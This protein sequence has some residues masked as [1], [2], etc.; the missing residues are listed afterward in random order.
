MVY[1]GLNQVKHI[2]VTV[3]AMGVLPR[4]TQSGMDMDAFLSHSLA[5][6]V[7]ARRL[8]QR[9]HVPTTHRQEHFVAGLLHDI[10]QAVWGNFRA[11]DYERVLALEADTG[12]A[13]HEA[14]LEI[15]GKSHCELGGL[16][17][18]RWQFS[19]PLIDAIRY[20]HEPAE[21]SADN[22]MRDTVY[23][24][25]QIAHVLRDEPHLPITERQVERFRGDIDEILPSLSGLDEELQQ[26]WTF[27]DL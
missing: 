22:T 26:A 3:A 8:A 17:A 11:D 20:H 25:N 16:L 10:G 19:Q 7:I 15:F 21:H 14:E 1:L 4:T 13:R 27:M 23:V 18:E 5:T 2:A 6:A 9:I 12:L 24:G